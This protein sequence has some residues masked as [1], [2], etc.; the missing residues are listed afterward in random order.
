LKVEEG[1]SQNGGGKEEGVETSFHDL[2]RFQRM[3]TMISIENA[4]LFKMS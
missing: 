3:K 1:G 2:G 4:Q